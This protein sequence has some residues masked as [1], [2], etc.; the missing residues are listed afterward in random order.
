MPIKL[1]IATFNLENLD[2]KPR[3]KST[4][5]ERIA[6]MP[7]QLLRLNINIVCLQKVTRQQ[8]SG[9]PR[10]ILALKKLLENTPFNDYN[11]AT[12]TTV[13]PEQ[14]KYMTNVTSSLSVAFNIS[15]RQ[16]YKHKSLDPF[17][18]SS[19]DEPI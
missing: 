8:E 17:I 2:D 7:F 13:D 5:N 4:I 16:Q 10:R 15:E 19:S 6:V 3:E 18:S 14:V 9:Q 1:S 12:T 11:Q